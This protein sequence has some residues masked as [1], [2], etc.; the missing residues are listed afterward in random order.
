L[1]EYTELDLKSDSGVSSNYLSLR[2][3]AVW[4][5]ELAVRMH[6]MAVLAL[7]GRHPESRLEGGG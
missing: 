7:L 5:A 3:L 2:R 1:H 4:L 6:L